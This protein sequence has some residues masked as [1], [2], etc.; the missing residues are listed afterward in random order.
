[1][2]RGFSLWLDAI[3]ALAAFAVL[4]GHMAHIRFTGG[5]YYFLREWNIAS[6]AVVVFFVISGLVIAF[7]AQRDGDLKTY[8]YNRATRIFTVIVPALILTLLFDAI[9]T[10]ITMDAY[11]FGYYQHLSW[12]EF[13]FRGLTLTPQWLGV[14]EPVRLGSNGPIW[15][16]SYEV[17][18]YLIFGFAVFLSGARRL[19]LIALVAFLAG[20]PI[21]ALMPAWLLGVLVWRRVSNPDA[22]ALSRPLAWVLAIGA[23]VAMVALKWAGVADALAVLTAGAFAPAD[24]HA[25]LLYSDEVLWNS[26]LAVLMALHLIGV[27]PLMAAANWHGPEYLARSIRWL[28]GGSFSLYVM[29]YPTLQLLDATLPESLPLHD[30]WLLGI[31]LAVCFGFAALFERPLKTYR[32]WFATLTRRPTAVPAE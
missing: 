24:Y 20:V 18:Y 5:D 8:S 1:M 21:L 13:L 19:V 14:M 4:F 25:V 2:T 32:R 22:A 29:H 3:R 11:P 10:R 30:L 17:A 15:S 23:P 7:A 12:S 26:L 31:T 9:G 16:L 28:A 6:D 27:A